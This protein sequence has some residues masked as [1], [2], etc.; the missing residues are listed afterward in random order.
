VAFLLSLIFLTGQ[1]RILNF[2]KT[3]KQHFADQ[4]PNNGSKVHCALSTLYWFICP[5]LTTAKA[6]LCSQGC[7]QASFALFGH[8][9]INNF[10]KT[11]L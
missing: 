10:L 4:F 9:T 8:C 5:Y 2:S 1:Q 11:S 6:L 3:E 7:E